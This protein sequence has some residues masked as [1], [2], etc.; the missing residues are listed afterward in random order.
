MEEEK[1]KQVA[2]LAKSPGQDA[3]A[4]ELFSRERF[5]T[6]CTNAIDHPGYPF[7]SI[8]PYAV[9]Q[10]GDLIILAS[11]LAEHTRNFR[12]DPRVALFVRDTSRPEADLQTLSRVTALGTIEPAAREQVEKVFRAVHPK[13]GTYTRMDD[14]HFYRLKIE[15]IRYVGGFGRMSWVESS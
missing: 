1:R 8:V 15:A 6:L 5:G 9:D 4:R 10:S 12:A 11:E 2:E 14:F 3:E 13:S 7:G